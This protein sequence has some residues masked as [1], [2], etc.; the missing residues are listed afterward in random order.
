MPQ[1]DYHLDCDTSQG[2]ACVTI[3]RRDNGAWAGTVTAPAPAP[4]MQAAMA[5]VRGMEREAERG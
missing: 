4:A 5:L 3:R 1:A 2:P